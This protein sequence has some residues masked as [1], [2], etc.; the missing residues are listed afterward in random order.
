MGKWSMASCMALSNLV[1]DHCPILLS[2]VQT[3]YGKIPSRLFNSWFE[4]PGAVEKVVQLMGSFHFEGLPDLALDVKLKWV[5]R[6]LKE[7]VYNKKS[8]MDSSYNTKLKRLEELES[9]A[10]QRSL[11]QDEMEER[12]GCKTFITESDRLKSMDLQQKSRVRWAK[13]GDENTRYFHGVI[14]ANTR[15]NRIHGLHIDGVWVADPPLVKDHVF[16]YFADKFVEPLYARPT[17]Q[18]PYLSQLSNDEANALLNSGCMSSFLALIPKRS[19]PGG[20][21]EYRPISLIGCINK[22]VSKVLVNRLKIVIHKL[23]SEEQTGFLSGRSILDGVIIL[24]E[25]IPWLKKN[26]REGMILKVDIE[27]AYDSLSWEFLNSMLCQMNFPEKWRGWVMSIVSSARASVLV[28]GSPTQEFTCSRGLRQGDPLSPFLFVLAMEAL[29]GIMKKACDTGV[30]KGL[31]LSAN[32]VSI[33]HFLYADDVVFVGDWSYD[34]MINLKRLL[35]CFYLSSGLKVNLKKNSLYGVGVDDN[36]VQL[37][38]NMLG[39]TRGSLP[40]KYL[41]LQVGANMNLVKNWDPVVEIFKRR[42]ALW[43][44]NTISFG[45][46]ITLV[47]SV[48]N[49]L[50]TYYFSLFKAPL[51]VIKK[52]EKLRREFLWGSNPEKEKMKWVAWRNMMTPKDFGGMGFDLLRVV[53]LALLAKWWWRF[54]VERDSLW[55]KVVWEIH[56]NSRSWSF[57]PVKLSLTS[58]WKQICKISDDFET[59]G[60]SLES[61]FRGVP[62]SESII[63]FWKERWLFEVPLCEKFPALFLLE[64][65]K[66]ATIKDR[67]E[68]VAGS[69][70]LKFMWAG[71]P[72]TSMEISEL[73]ELSD[74]LS[75]FVYGLGEDKWSWLLDPSGFFSVNSVKVKL[76]KLI[77]VDLKLAFEWNN[78]SP[79]KVN[80]LIWRLVQDKL[81]TYS[82]LARRNVIVQ[83]NRCKMCGGEAETTIHL[84]VSCS[85]AEQIW[86]FVSRWCR[87][88]QVFALELKDLANIHKR[89]RGSQRWK[90]VVNLVTQA[91]IWV[92]WRSRNGAVF[93]GKQPHVNRMKEEIKMFGYMWLKSRV[94]GTN[95]SWEDWCEFNLISIGV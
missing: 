44:A 12:M 74:A 5:K 15:N 14:N 19:D 64:R 71:Q 21:H 34:N 56:K 27:K 91:A 48:L 45:G 65:H 55:K 73:Q 82:A 62:G 38:A 58:P 40:F 81:P 86:E 11:D 36:Q 32:G 60:L 70:E 31:G 69:L 50:P 20:L 57:I 22:V 83:D 85:I 10:E 18:C 26:K 39:C 84:F 52:L 75:S 6:R 49:A 93:E 42:L 95:I 89:N 9:M 68:V 76:Q 79:K 24:N 13:E 35:R 90:K 28:N 37:M 17:L 1:S 25:L 59:L 54:K 92:I 77:F 41:G 16:S 53:N 47:S 43:K 88:Q 8:E 46:R 29:T 67:L 2:T 4:I 33:S 51:G 72:S 87:I 23:V 63:S 78:W 94:K 30:F 3:D 7:W 66:N 80:F 61:M